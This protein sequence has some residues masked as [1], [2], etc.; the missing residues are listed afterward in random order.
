[1]LDQ[2]VISLAPEGDSGEAPRA[3]RPP[4]L[5]RALQRLLAEDIER[6]RVEKPSRSPPP[7]QG[8]FATPENDSF[9]RSY[10]YSDL[11]HTAQDIR[12]VRVFKD[13]HCNLIQCEFLPQSSL[14]EASGRYH[15][16]SYCA[17]DP[18]KTKP[19][20]LE[21]VQF[22]VFSNLYHA[23]EKTLAIWNPGGECILWIDQICINQHN[24]AERSHQVG[25]MRDIYTNS[26]GTFISLST[27]DTGGTGPNGLDWLKEFDEAYEAYRRGG[28]KHKVLFDISSAFRSPRNI[29]QHILQE[30]LSS[31]AFME[32]WAS[33]YD[34]VQC[35]WWRRAWIHQEFICSPKAIFMYH[36][37]T[38]LSSRTSFL[39]LLCQVLQDFRIDDYFY[40][41]ATR[42]R[43]R[44]TKGDR[45]RLIEVYKRNMHA[46][47]S[48][49]AIELL[50]N[51]KTTWRG[52]EDLKKVLAGSRH[53]RSSD[54][55]DR[56]FAFLGLAHPGYDVETN[57]GKSN[58]L[59]AII[60][61]TAKKIFEFERDLEILAFAVRTTKARLGVL[62]SWVPD[63]AS[64]EIL[65]DGHF[66]ELPGQDKQFRHDAIGSSVIQLSPDANN[67][68]L[69]V[70]GLHIDTL[71]RHLPVW[72]NAFYD[73]A[74]VTI[75]GHTV[76]SRSFAQE[77]DELW[78]LMGS[79]WPFVLR[80]CAN[81]YMVISEA[82]NID[83][84]ARP[85]EKIHS[86]EILSRMR[87][88]LE[89]LRIIYLC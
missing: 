60:L 3:R 40:H 85:A 42:Y 2:R 18:L 55:R 69:R 83:L 16:L 15:T 78:M 46:S 43:A 19:I 68:V 27:A 47:D 39:L 56:V 23:L 25:F 13:C 59:D 45:D 54:P 75:R 72:A 9:R 81:G 32:G 5:R 28:A 63:W 89:R 37:S 49:K 76:R 77:G 31:P 6:T 38:I 82:E 66:A 64:T 12:L 7:T 87:K 34:F 51:S 35:P 71:E 24:D 58:T 22:N 65:E 67:V 74:F 53:C 79:K 30:N 17:G 36:D 57:Y 84:S 86:D 14:Q 26:R 20:L 52:D 70:R 10:S 44:A 88:G 1:M 29:V 80:P 41:L 21:G 73:A 4:R 48:L 11:D 61:H 50:L 33:F 8:I 62:P